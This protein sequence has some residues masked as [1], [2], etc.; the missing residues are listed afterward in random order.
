ML[1][2]NWE[3]KGIHFVLW[4]WGYQVCRGSKTMAT[5]VRSKEITCIYTQEEHGNRELGEAINPQGLPSFTHS[6]QGSIYF[7]KFLKPP[8]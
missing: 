1:R 5:G 4:F 8:Q 2:N 7:P 3:D 6:W